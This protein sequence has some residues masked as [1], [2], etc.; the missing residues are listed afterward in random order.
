MNPD[1]FCGWQIPGV[2][3]KKEVTAR[4]LLENAADQIRVFVLS[5]SSVVPVITA[6][7]NMP[8][9]ETLR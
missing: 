8:C 6:T 9:S 2:L 1:L 4:A 5:P 3:Y 7:V